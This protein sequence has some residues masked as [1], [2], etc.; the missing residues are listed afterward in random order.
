[1]IT[2]PIGDLLTRIRNGQRAGHRTVRV[3]K[4]ATGKRVLE[5]LREEGFIAGIEEK[6]NAEGN[7]K[8]YEVTLKYYSNGSPCITNLV[9][10][11]KP[12]YR[13]YVRTEK[14]P[15]VQSG[16]GIAIV[17]T[18]SGVM[19]DREARKK[20]IGGELLATVS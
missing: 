13:K 20:K 11:S 5:V 7:F 8:E 15:K 16:L 12:G 17:S 19:S 1:M 9:R 18:S 6:P 4:S 14:L 2:D 10:C 3:R